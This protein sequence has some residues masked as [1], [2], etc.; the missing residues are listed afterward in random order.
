MKCGACGAVGHMKTNKACPLY[1]GRSNL[2]SVQVAMTEEQEEEIEKVGL[3]EDDLVNV[4]GTKLT[5]SKQL[6]MHA[7]EIRRKSLL[8]KF[9]KEA[10]G[11]NKRRRAG[12]FIHCD[13]LKKPHKAANRRRIDPV[14]TMSTIFESILNDI[15]D[16]PDVSVLI[17]ARLGT[18][19]CRP[20]YPHCP[21]WHIVTCP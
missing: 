8:L 7:D 13:Y 5:L 20:C 21:F 1:Q 6:V 14:V 17:L 16:M 9:P 19:S 3:E 10:V 11:K 18:D 12:T 4:D 2:P 15:R